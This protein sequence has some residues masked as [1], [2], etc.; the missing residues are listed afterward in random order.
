M[1]RIVVD[2]DIININKDSNYIIKDHRKRYVFNINNSMVNVLSIKENQDDE[3]YEI[4]INGGKLILNNVCYNQKNLDIIVNLNSVK[5]EVLIYNSVVTDTKK[6]VTIRINHNEKNTISNVYNNGVTR[7][8]GSINFDVTSYVPNGVKGCFVNQDSKI[9]SLND[10]NSNE[11][12][13]ILLIDEYDVE[14][15]H[16][17]FIG[18]FNEQ[19]LFY[20]MS[21][22]LKKEEA[23]NLLLNG[24]LVGTLDVCFEEKENLKKKFNDEWR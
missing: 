15:R 24:M 10:K 19:E 7:K 13:P 2:K 4:N 8:D 22:G 17:A 1:N 14:A 20:L 3:K 12:N 6:K 16:A 5:S 21:R 9:I 11:I 18:K 23:E